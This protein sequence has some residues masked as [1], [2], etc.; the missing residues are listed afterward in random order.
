MSVL[1]GKVAPFFHDASKMFAAVEGDGNIVENFNFQKATVNQ[2]AVVFFYPLDFTFVCP[3]EL[4]AFHNRL[5]AF[6][7]RN[8]VVISVSLDS[9]FTHAAWRNTPIEKGGVGPLGYIMVSD[10]KREI[11]QAYDVESSNGVALR[12]S[13]LIDKVGVV[14]HQV[15]NNLPL[16]RNVDEMLR[17]IDALQFSEKHGEVCPAGWKKGH[18]GMQPNA[19]GVATY[20]AKHAQSL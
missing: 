10:I 5:Q 8:T 6:Q 16:G 17:M 2:Y 13:F 18:D 14:Q 3:S 11:I 7:E 1:V 19:K 9:H 12:G 4:I 15:V 20:L